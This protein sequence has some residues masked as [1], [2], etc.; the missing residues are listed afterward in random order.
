[1]DRKLE[2]IAFL[3]ILFF[4]CS[5]RLFS[6]PL[7][8]NDQGYFEKQGIN[9][10]VFSNNYNGMF[11]DEKTAGIELIHH[12]VRT[13][14]GGAVRLQNTP[15]QWDLVPE[16]VSRTVD[17]E[18]N[19]IN[20]EL[21]YEEFDFN[22]KIRV[23]AKDR[24]VEIAV[25]LDK[26]LPEK[27][28]GAAGFNLE[29]LPASYF[30]KNYFVD[31][32]P[33]IFPRYPAGQTKIEP[34]SEKIPQFAGH[35]TFEDRG[36]DEFIVPFPLT[37]GK[38][39]VLAPEDPANYVKIQSDTPISLFDG[40]NLA[41]NGWFIVRS[42][43]PANK[44]G[45]V[46]SWYLEPNAIAGWVR[47]PVVGFSQV[48]YV[49]EQQ[50]V[51]VIELDTNDSALESASIYR[52]TED[53]K[54]QKV[55]DGKVTLWGQYL[56]YNYAKFDFSEVKDP[57]IYCIRY[58]DQ[59]TNT[60]PIDPGIYQDVWHPT[61]DVW[62]PVQ[63]DHMQVN[64]AYRTW[65]GEPY[66]DDCL[67]APV[68][69]E[70]FDGYRQ[71]PTTETK[72]KPL[73]RIP[74]MAVGG[75]FDAG[76]FDIQTGSHNSVISNFV[77]LWEEFK[78]DRDETYIDQKTRYVDIHRP[79]G[80]PD[81]LQQIEHGTLN[82]VAQCENIG[83]PVRGIIVPNLHQYHHLGDASTETDNLPYNPNLKPYETDG[84]SSGTLDDRW[85]FTNRSSFL[86]YQTA[87][88]L[89][90]AARAL[91]GYNDDLAA[92]S[93]ASATRLL[94][95]ADEALKNAA[96]SSDEPWMRMMARGA[97]LNTVLQLYI[98]TKE[99]KHLDRFEAKIWDALEQPA[100]NRDFGQ[101]FF[102]GRSLVPALKA[103]PYLGDAYKEKLKGYIVKYN[104]SIVEMEKSNPY[105]LPISRSG[106][107]GSGMIVN[108]AITSY[109]AHE[110]FPDIIS[111]D[112]VFNGLNF[113][114]GCHPYSNISFVNAVGTRSKK[115][116]YG[117]N[118]ADFT[119]I[120]GGIVPGLLLL[121]PDFLEN[122]DDWPFLWGENEVT[123]GGSA[124]YIFLSNAVQHLVSE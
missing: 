69:H 95:E 5:T 59:Q 45:K 21:R 81:I 77:D 109:Y 46:L 116:A 7:K 80:K 111:K 52:V 70:H 27:L 67:Q 120:A 42:L 113:I 51:A 1:M 57:G 18:N 118:R 61:L 40:R 35:T 29:F 37:S 33:G 12:G 75:W 64:E 19:I 115:V 94:E 74:G 9:V 101:M 123:I 108:V 68:N 49:P 38:T 66:K 58:G 41:Q 3:A 73:E 56:R 13:A 117:N 86:E 24:G 87:A 119:T 63:M 98:T 124:E 92:R 83:H 32:N 65:H 20:V 14:T 11:F 121:K 47:K 82:L 72:Y 76:D 48:G 6:Q 39:V 79:D 2:M 122:K 26:P 43:L 112:E 107:G 36:R 53:G 31:G 103:I 97:D 34:K 78:V 99:K 17:R 30:E 28:E 10:L 106:W 54:Y 102:A 105:G 114:F 22:S 93:L 100:G 4:S 62:F 110:A 60:F 8:I 84:V 88:S 85:A 16:L 104:E 15:E 23:T 71:G 96:D 91:K 55:L 90:A 25:F 89:A 50:K 44:T